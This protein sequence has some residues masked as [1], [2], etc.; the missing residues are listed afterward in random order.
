MV[1]GLVKGTMTR[2]VSAF[3]EDLPRTSLSKE[4]GPDEGT[5]P[6]EVLCEPTGL[7]VLLFAALTSV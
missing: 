7:F 1:E 5:Q 6:K 4:R 2:G 3:T